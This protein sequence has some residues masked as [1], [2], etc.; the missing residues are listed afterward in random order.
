MGRTKGYVFMFLG[1]T[2]GK[3][4]PKFP[5]KHCSSRDNLIRRS[6]VNSKDKT[7]KT[8]SFFVLFCFKGLS[9]FYE[10]FD[11]RNILLISD[12]SFHRIF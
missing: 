2:G 4:K 6:L 10:Y 1:K 5:K 3:Y 8:T 7:K 9:L 11:F 12:F